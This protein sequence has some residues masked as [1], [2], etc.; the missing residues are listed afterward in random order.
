LI[1]LNFSPKS[2]IES[3]VANRAFSLKTRLTECT[4]F[5]KPSA[6]RYITCNSGLVA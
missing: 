5:L 6:H 4:S 2:Q 3:V 1:G